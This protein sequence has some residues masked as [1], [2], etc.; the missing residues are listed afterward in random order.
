MFAYQ[1]SDPSGPANPLEEPYTHIISKPY[2]FQTTP[3]QLFVTPLGFK[4]TD[5][6]CPETE[7]FSAGW[8]RTEYAV[9]TGGVYE[10]CAG[11]R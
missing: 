7:A 9:E 11:G 3:R 5:Q 4:V 8:G 10:V 6:V 1:S 2:P